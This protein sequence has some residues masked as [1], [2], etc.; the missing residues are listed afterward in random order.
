M[1]RITSDPFGVPARLAALALAVLVGVALGLIFGGGPS[2][3]EEQ[4]SI[5]EVA[6]AYGASDGAEACEFMSASALDQLGGASGCT[7]QFETVPS[8]EFEIQDVT[9]TDD[10]ATATVRNLAPQ[11]RVIELGLVKEGDAWKVAEFP[12]LETIQPPTDAPDELAP[13][14][15][16]QDGV[17]ETA[18]EEPRETTDET[19]PDDETTEETTGGS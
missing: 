1:R 19:A 8:A 5:E 12:G 18:P 7:E 14:V 16:P 2:P 4:R 6:V 3:E 17:T 13:P 9:L 11:G 10:T 15:E